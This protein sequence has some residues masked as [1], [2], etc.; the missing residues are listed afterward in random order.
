MLVPSGLARKTSPDAFRAGASVQCKNWILPLGSVLDEGKQLFAPGKLRFRTGWKYIFGATPRILTLGVPEVNANCRKSP[1]QS[2]GLLRTRFWSLRDSLE[3][4]IR[5]GFVQPGFEVWECP[6]GEPDGVF[7]AS[8]EAA[9]A[10]SM[11]TVEYNFAE[12]PALLQVFM[13]SANFVQRKHSIDHRLQASGE[14]VAKHLA[15]LRHRAHVG[16]HNRELA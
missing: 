8:G 3:G 1:G 2:S 14:D 9:D 12:H 11:R 10:N 16:T 7:Q 15:Q 6:V 5:I 13:C 4:K